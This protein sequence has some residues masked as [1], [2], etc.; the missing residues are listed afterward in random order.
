[1]R[2]PP[3]ALRR[4]SPAH[5][6]KQLSTGLWLRSLSPTRTLPRAFAT[7]WVLSGKP[8]TEGP[9]ARAPPLCSRPHQLGRHRHLFTSVSP[10]VLISLWRKPACL[11]QGLVFPVITRH[12][13]NV[14]QGCLTP[15]PS[16]TPSFSCSGLGN[17]LTESASEVGPC[18]LPGSGRNKQGSVNFLWPCDKLWF[19]SC[20]FS[21]ISRGQV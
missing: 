18:G 7:C 9:R 2:C 5:P 3:A 11:S 13:Q 16:G 10:R 21:Y 8:F 6:G 20:G 12:S 14:Q 17:S 1:M 19:K 4:I 15:E